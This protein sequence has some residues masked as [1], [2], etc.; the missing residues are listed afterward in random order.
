LE[1]SRKYRE[2]ARL[3]AVQAAREKASAMATQL[4]QSIGKPWEI[5]EESLSDY[6][7]GMYTNFLAEDKRML[8]EQSTVAGG[9][10]TI[11]ASVRVSFLWE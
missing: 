9:Q 7:R 4:G 6:S 1:N 2:K 5:T 11:R 8:T 10:V 3:E